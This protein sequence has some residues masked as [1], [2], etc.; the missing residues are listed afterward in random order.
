MISFWQSM[1]NTKSALAVSLS[2]SIVWPAIL[3]SLL[4]LFFGNEVIWLCHSLSEALTAGTAFVLLAR[5]K[6]KD[7][8]NAS[9]KVWYN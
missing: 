5:Q 1:Q 7:A 8:I 6:S 2:R 4:P 3:T 9:P